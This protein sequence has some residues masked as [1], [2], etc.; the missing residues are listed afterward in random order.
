[1]LPRWAEKD[2]D[3]LDRAFT[4]VRS[5]LDQSM[6][7]A[8]GGHVPTW[9]PVQDSDA[10]RK[11]KPQS[12]Y[13]AAAEAAAYD[14]PGWYS[15]SGSNFEN[16]V[17]SAVAGVRAGRQSPAAAIDQMRTSLQEFADTPAPV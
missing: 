13:A 9:L 10:Y 11:L 14:P 17:G 4:F 2:S 12:A 16:V 8:A 15:G 6:T 7:W 1:V 3:R 5:L